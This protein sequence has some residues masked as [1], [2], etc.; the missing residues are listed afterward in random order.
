M[1]LTPQQRAELERQRLQSPQ[2]SRAVI[3]LT[4]A[5][6]NEYQRQVAKELSYRDQVIQDSRP[7][8][9]ALYEP[10]FSGD[11]RRA[12]AGCGIDH[13]RL[14]EQVHVDVNHLNAFLSGKSPLSS[15][16]IDRLAPALGLTLVARPV[17]E[18][19]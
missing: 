14:C 5:Q 18:Q 17:D 3:Q 8:L 11:L 12:I 15:D 4:D 19:G 6:R 2:A 9:E 16:M 1:K 10:G 13:H 7:L